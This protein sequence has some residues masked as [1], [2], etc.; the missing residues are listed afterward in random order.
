MQRI[1]LVEKNNLKSKVT[2]THT[3]THTYIYGKKK[4]IYLS[5]SVSSLSL[6]TYPFYIHV[7]LKNNPLSLQLV[8]GPK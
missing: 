3:Y 7:L 8:M 4:K 6:S 1:T 2:K 5:V